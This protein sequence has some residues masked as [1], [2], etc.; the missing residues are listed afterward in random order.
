MSPF[1]IVEILHL[2]KKKNK[3]HPSIYHEKE[4]VAISGKCSWT[5]IGNFYNEMSM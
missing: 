3:N 2:D 1:Y 4:V 5:P